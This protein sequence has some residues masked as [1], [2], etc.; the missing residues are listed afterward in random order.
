[1]SVF[2]YKVKKKLQNKNCCY[3]SERNLTEELTVKYP[4]VE[5]LFRFGAYAILPDARAFIS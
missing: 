5:G 2:F 3:A 4:S 1:V